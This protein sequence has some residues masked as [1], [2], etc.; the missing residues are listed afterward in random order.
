MQEYC[1][2]AGSTSNIHSTHTMKLKMLSAAMLLPVVGVK[3]M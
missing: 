3:E 2:T 1:V